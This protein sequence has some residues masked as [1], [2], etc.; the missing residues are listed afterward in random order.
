MNYCIQPNYWSWP[1]GV[2]ATS[3]GL[4]LPKRA[5]LVVSNLGPMVLRI[6][7]TVRW[8]FSIRT[9]AVTVSENFPWYMSKVILG[10]SF[11]QAVD[12]ESLMQ[13]TKIQP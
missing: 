4:C 2:W 5:N 13:Y 7:V 11:E 10:S 3:A 9:K 12:L 1:S 6:K 8:W